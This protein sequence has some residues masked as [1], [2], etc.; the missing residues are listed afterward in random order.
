M[1]Q[2]EV[3]MMQVQSNFMMSLCIRML[4]RRLLVVISVQKVQIPQY[5]IMYRHINPKVVKKAGLS[6]NAHHIDRII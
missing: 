5:T 2:P 4:I 6:V 3:A 1:L